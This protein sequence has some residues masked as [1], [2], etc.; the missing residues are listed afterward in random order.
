M[1]EIANTR[2][3]ESTHP[4]S[5]TIYALIHMKASIPPHNCHIKESPL[6][7][8]AIGGHQGRSVSE[9]CGRLQ[10]VA[11]TRRVASTL[12]LLDGGTFW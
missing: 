12:N 2:V 11:L 9:E 5:Y 7:S 3:L 1:C 10:E 8:Q 6:W 4:W